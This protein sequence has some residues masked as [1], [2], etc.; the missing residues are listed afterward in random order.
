MQFSTSRDAEFWFEESLRKRGV[1]AI[2]QKTIKEY[3]KGGRWA[4]PKLYVCDHKEAFLVTFWRN[5]TANIKSSVKVSSVGQELDKRLKDA[6]QD[7]GLNEAE[8]TQ[9]K[10]ETLMTLLELEYSESFETFLVTIYACGD[11]YW[12]R[13]QDFYQFATRHGTY[14]QFASSPDMMRSLPYR[15]PTGWMHRWE[16]R[17]L[18]KNPPAVL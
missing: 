10:E 9:C 6:L 11:V 1:E 4:Y 17:N 2:E 13:T 15:V 5:K 18:V 3:V 14:Q 7:F 16:A 8:M 12:C